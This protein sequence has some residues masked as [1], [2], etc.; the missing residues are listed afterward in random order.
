MFMAWPWVS[1]RPGANLSW[2]RYIITN[3][4]VPGD[5]LDQCCWIWQTFETKFGMKHKFSKYLNESCRKNSD[6]Y[7]SFKHF[8]YIAFVREISPKLSGGFGC[9]RHDW[10]K[11]QYRNDPVW[12][13]FDHWVTFFCLKNLNQYSVCVKYQYLQSIWDWLKYPI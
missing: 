4:F 12:F 11:I 6:E 2:I 9:Y 10:V 1:G 7:S 8:L 13:C 3:S 5:L